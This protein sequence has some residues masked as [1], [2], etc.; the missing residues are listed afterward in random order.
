[1]NEVRSPLRGAAKAI[2]EGFGSEPVKLD[3]KAGG[4]SFDA[5]N[6][7]W[8]A[9]NGF[10]GIYSILSGGFPAWSGEP[11]STETALNHSVVWACNRIISESVGFIP[12]VML[13]QKGDAIR[14][15]GN[16]ITAADSRVRTESS[17]DQRIVLERASGRRV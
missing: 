13:Q 1:L 11:V 16:S 2:R 3:L 15:N 6:A 12:A 5:V 14:G 17:P 7:G 8:Y 9:R 10:P 4:I